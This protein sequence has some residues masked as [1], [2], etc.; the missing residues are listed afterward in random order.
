VNPYDLAHQLAKALSESDEYKEYKKARE[1]LEQDPKAKEMVKDL[2]EKQLEVEAQ[3]LSGK[4]SDEATK[5]LENLYNIAKFNSLVSK[6]LESEHRFAFMM[7]D[8][9][10][11]LAKAVE[12]DIQ[13]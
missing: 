6:Y 7:M 13:N 1:L 2:R 5:A 11:I 8:I 3:K 4:P 10:K 12:I 9:Q